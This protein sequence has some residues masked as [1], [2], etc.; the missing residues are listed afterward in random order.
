MKIG[1]AASLRVAFDAAL[2]V[3]FKVKVTG[4]FESQAQCLASLAGS[5]E[6]SRSCLSL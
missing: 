1:I 4:R 2:A 3:G 6:L 5:T